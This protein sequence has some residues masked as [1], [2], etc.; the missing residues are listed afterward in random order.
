MCVSTGMWWAAET[1]WAVRALEHS[2]CCASWPAGRAVGLPCCPY[3]LFIEDPSLK[4][5]WA[6][7]LGPEPPP[8]SQQLC[9]LWPG[10]V[11]WS[12][13]GV[14]TQQVL[15]PR[16]FPKAEDNFYPPQLWCELN[17]SSRTERGWTAIGWSPFEWT[18]PPVAEG[19]GAQPTVGTSV[20]V[21]MVWIPVLLM[22]PSYYT[23]IDR[24]QGNRQN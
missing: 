4:R 20:C 10:R 23:G 7:G 14:W 24:C 15:P 22:V 8:R 9:P 6:W 3:N 17:S 19:G 5:V 2:D 16:A 12:A 13:R 21:T 18:A 11:P 1:S